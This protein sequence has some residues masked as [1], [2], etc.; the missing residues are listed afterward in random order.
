MAKDIRRHTMRIG[1][2]E[3]VPPPMGF[4]II[5]LK[6]SFIIQSFVCICMV[7]FMKIKTHLPHPLRQWRRVLRSRQK[8]LPQP[9]PQPQRWS[10]LKSTFVWRVR[11][12]FGTLTPLQILGL[13]ELWSL[14]DCN[15]ERETQHYNTSRPYFVETS[16]PHIVLAI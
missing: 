7:A 10:L 8:T 4:C 1:F 14:V 2:L 16:F 11:H 13:D 12:T 5:S 15:T 3:P 9:S 6:S